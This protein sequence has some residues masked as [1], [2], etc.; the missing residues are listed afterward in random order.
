MNRTHIIAI[1]LIVASI[2][3]AG[4]AAWLFHRHKQ[5]QP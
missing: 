4:G 3:L 1:T 5:A 2:A